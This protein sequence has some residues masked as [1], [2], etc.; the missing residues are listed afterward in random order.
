[1]ATRAIK[2]AA[3]QSRVTVTS[4]TFYYRLDIDSSAIQY[5]TS[6]LLSVSIFIFSVYRPCGRFFLFF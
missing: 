4:R 2:N 6:Y 1:M 5:S 3:Y